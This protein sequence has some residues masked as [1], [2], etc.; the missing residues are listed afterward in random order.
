VSDDT[1]RAYVTGQFD[2]LRAAVAHGDADAADRIVDQVDADGHPQVADAMAAGLARTSLA[3]QLAEPAYTTTDS[4]VSDAVRA[5]ADRLVELSRWIDESPANA[6]RDPEAL[7]WVRVAKLAEEAGEAVAALIA[8]T[9]ANPRKGVHGTPTQVD[10]ELLDVALTALAAYE[11][12]TGH[13][14]FAFAALFG[15]IEA[16]HARAGLADPGGPA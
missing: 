10:A 3:G 6:G 12:R 4:I 16:V 8:A 5:S 1:R 14:G 2:Q 9:G 15:H 7:T 13:M 11:H